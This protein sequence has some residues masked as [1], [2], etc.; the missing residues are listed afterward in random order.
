MKNLVPWEW[1]KRKW[2]VLVCLHKQRTIWHLMESKPDYN[3]EHF[4]QQSYSKTS[5]WHV[6]SSLD[7]FNI[8]GYIRLLLV[9][10]SVDSVDLDLICSLV[11][12]SHA[13]VSDSLWFCL[14]ESTYRHQ[15]NIDDEL[16]TMEILD[17]AGQV[18][19]INLPVHYESVMNKITKRLIPNIPGWL[20]ENFLKK[21]K[22]PAALMSST[23][24]KLFNNQHTTSISQSINQQHKVIQT[25]KNQTWKKLILCKR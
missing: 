3:I 18:R 7:G 1:N 25:E 17:T 23:Q 5:H 22:R 19:E 8:Y 21:K 15:A 4:P 11:T 12:V 20:W 16:V 14:P 9:K 13:E 10:M 24:A 6:T 2:T